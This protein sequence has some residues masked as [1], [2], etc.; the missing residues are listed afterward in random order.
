MLEPAEI[1]GSFYSE[2][3]KLFSFITTS[4]CFIAGYSSTPFKKS[5]FFNKY[6]SAVFI[7]LGE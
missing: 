4:A 2:L 5:K 7:I 6:I 3:N 1:A